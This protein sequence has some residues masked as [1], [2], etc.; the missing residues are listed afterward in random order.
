MEIYKWLG[1]AGQQAECLIKLAFLLQDVKRLDAAEEAASRAIDL[2]PE[3][4]NRFV[5]CRSHRVL[6]DIYRSKGETEKAVHH[7]ELALGI[8]SSLNWHNMTFL[9]HFCLAELFLR[10]CRFDDAENHIKQAK[11]HTDN[12]AYNLGRAM[13]LRAKICSKQHRFEEARSEALRAVE[14]F[15]KLGAV[16]KME[17]CKRL[18]QNIR[19]KSGKRNRAVR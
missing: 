2:A 6:G 11:S 12:S 15:E 7:Y 19:K 17:K 9:V 13:E 16:K 1:D 14:T 4:D 3:E 8:T 18:L 10:R 5:V